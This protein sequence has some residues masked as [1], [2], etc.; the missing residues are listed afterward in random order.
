MYTELFFREK[1][2]ITWKEGNSLKSGVQDVLV[3][4]M[5]HWK[6]TLIENNYLGDWSPKKD[7][8]LK[9]SKIYNKL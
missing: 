7:C 8:S 3:E 9:V 1:W 6:V 4:N 5:M 2:D